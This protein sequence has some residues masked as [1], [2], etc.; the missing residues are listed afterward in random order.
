LLFAGHL[1]VAFM[2]VENYRV[3]CLDTCFQSGLKSLSGVPVN[4]EPVPGNPDNSWLNGLLKIERD[5]SP[6]VVLAQKE[7]EERYT[8]SVHYLLRLRYSL[9]SPFNFFSFSNFEQT[10]KCGAKR[11][12]KNQKCHY[13]LVADKS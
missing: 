3:S 4:I 8:N 9:R 10:F 7:E 12:C 5:V 2:A 13:S 11:L 6:P 1:A